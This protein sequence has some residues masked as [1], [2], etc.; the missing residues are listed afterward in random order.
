[1]KVVLWVVAVAALI[2]GLHRLAL[3]AD[4]KGMLFYRTKPHAGALSTAF[5]VLEQ[6]Y[7]PEMEHTVEM[8]QSIGLFEE[9]SGDP[10]DGREG[11]EAREGRPTLSGEGG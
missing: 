8:Q 9:L 1:M 6:F 10:P 4:R 3:L 7:R 11:G 5:G 2:Y